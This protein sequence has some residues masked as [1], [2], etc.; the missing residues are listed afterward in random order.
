M[1]T[2]LQ[3]CT[4]MD[5]VFQTK[6]GVHNFDGAAERLGVGATYDEMERRIAYLEAMEAIALKDHPELD[7]CAE[8]TG[9]GVRMCATPLGYDTTGEMLS[10][11]Y[12]LAPDGTLPSKVRRDLMVTLG[13]AERLRHYLRHKDRCKERSGCLVCELFGRLLVVTNKDAR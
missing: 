9:F 8:K 11:V 2:L 10:A 3:I 13:D 7:G 12:A 4:H 5:E 6:R 1:R